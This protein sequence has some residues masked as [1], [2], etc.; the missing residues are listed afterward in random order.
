SIDQF[1]SLDRQ[2]SELLEKSMEQNGFSARVA[3]KLL[4]VA[5]TLADMESAPEIQDRHL[6][7]ALGFRPRVQQAQ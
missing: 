2:L 4:K 1:C 3:H 6:F 7:E 5:R